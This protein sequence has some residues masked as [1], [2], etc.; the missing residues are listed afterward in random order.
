MAEILKPAYQ[1]VRDALKWYEHRDD[2]AYFFG[3]KWVI[4]TDAVMDYLIEQENWYFKRYDEKQLKAIK[5][6]SRGKVGADCSAYICKSIG[7][8]MISSAQ[9][10]ARC[11]NKT[12]V[13]ECKAGSLLRY[14]DHIGLDIG[15]G[16]CLHIGKE[17]ESIRL[18]KNDKLGWIGGGEFDLLDYSMMVNY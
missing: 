1:P 8:D 3:A 2:I 10:W 16:Y 4:L 7:C 12:G 14:P 18:E 13:K 11:N 15:Y 6:W 5:E 17:L 9:L